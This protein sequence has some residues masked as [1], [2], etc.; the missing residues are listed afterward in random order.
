MTAQG[1]Q[2]ELPADADRFRKIAEDWVLWDNLGMMR[3]LGMG[4]EPPAP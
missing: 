4:P 1:A 3:Q 2:R